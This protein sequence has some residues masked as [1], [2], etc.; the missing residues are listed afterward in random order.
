M[1]IIRTCISIDSLVLDMSD[2]LYKKVQCSQD[3]VPK[4][5]PGQI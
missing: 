3:R 4:A 2:L 1:L 5:P